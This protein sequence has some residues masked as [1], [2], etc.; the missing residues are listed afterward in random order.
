MPI[1]LLPLPSPSPLAVLP[2]QLPRFLFLSTL[3]SLSLFPNTY[4]VH[5]LIVEGACKLYQPA[6]NNSSGA[7]KKEYTVSAP[8]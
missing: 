3:Y 2:S 8:W 7:E 1:L 6:R 5:I 4:F